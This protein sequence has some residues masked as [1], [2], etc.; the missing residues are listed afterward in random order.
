VQSSP[1]VGIGIN[2]HRIRGLMRFVEMTSR[3]SK[4]EDNEQVVGTPNCKSELISSQGG[5]ISFILKNEFSKSRTIK[6][7]LRTVGQLCNQMLIF[8]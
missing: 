7:D 4:I 8:L 3:E 2:D 6:G 5:L 1:I